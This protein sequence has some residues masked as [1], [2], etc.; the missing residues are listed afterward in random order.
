MRL[1]FAMCCFTAAVYA[2][3]PVPF[4]LDIQLAEP[5][6]AHH[7]QATFDAFLSPD[8]DAAAAEVASLEQTLGPYHPDLAARLVDVAELALKSGDIVLA[9]EFY[10]RALHNSRVNNGLYGDQQLPILRGLLDLYLLTG[11]R[12]AF[13]AR[14]AYQFRLLGSGL[15]P[16]EQGELQAALEF[17]D[18]SLDALMDVP[19]EG[20]DRELIRLHDRFDAMAEAVCDDV[21]VKSRWCEP[22]T[23]RLARFYYLLEF[24]LEAF[25]DDPRFE[26]TFSDPNWQSMERE[27]RLEALQRRLFNRGETALERLLAVD[28][29]S[30]NAVSALADWNWFYRKRD[31]ALQLYAQ[32]CGIEPDRFKAAGP[33]P[34]YPQ[35]AFELAFQEA[36]VPVQLSLT[37]TERGQP[38]DV[39]LE[40]VGSGAGEAPPGRVR[41]SIRRMVFR[42]ALDDCSDATD[43]Q[44]NMDLMFLR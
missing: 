29:Q 26:R 14:A 38:R 30:H 8:L 41:R 37:V 27:P 11:D 31:R 32:A 18:V 34:E 4:G 15:P 13:E 23:F 16:F 9:G 21:S 2:D 20:R 39:V 28:P 24:K 10:D 25:V 44:L 12:E 3:T 42:P 7:S 40:L 17:F 6:H 1:L 5:L 19:W 43:S 22:F 33:L 35:L 36:P